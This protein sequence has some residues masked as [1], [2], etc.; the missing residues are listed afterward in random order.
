M[1]DKMGPQ[2]AAQRMIP[3]LAPMSTHPCLEQEQFD[4]LVGTIKSMI[5]SIEDWRSEEFKAKAEV[6]KHM[7]ENNAQEEFIKQQNF[8][9][10]VSNEFHEKQSS[11]PTNAASQKII[12]NAP[13]PTADSLSS[14]EDVIRSEESSRQKHLQS[15]N[16]QE[17]FSEIGGSS[18]HNTNTIDMSSFKNLQIGSNEPTN[19]DFNFD[20]FAIE[21]APSGPK[22]PKTTIQ[23]SVEPLNNTGVSTNTVISPQNTST[24]TAPQINYYQISLSRCYSI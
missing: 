20:S 12:D 2:I 21:K 17:I 1:N 19:Q 22:R 15:K 18:V 24:N 6:A 23:K 3:L 4:L 9:N 8:Q 16:Q 5:K 14:F 10:L 7:D 11:I 13:P